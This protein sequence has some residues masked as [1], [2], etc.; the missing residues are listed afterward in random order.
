MLIFLVS[1]TSFSVGTIL[2]WTAPAGPQLK[3]VLDDEYKF[4]V[5]DTA[6]SWIASAM[7]LG[8]A[9]T[10]VPAGLA[11]NKFGR[12]FTLLSSL[13]LALVGWG[14]ILAAT[15]VKMMIFGRIFLGITVGI[16]QVVGS[17]YIGE[18]ATKDI[19]GILGTFLHF[20]LALGVLFVYSVGAGIRIF[21]LSVVCAI[22]PII[23]GAIFVFMPETPSYLVQANKKD[24]AEK[25]LKWLRGESYNIKKELETLENEDQA[26]KL[27][28]DGLSL[29][30]KVKQPGAIRCLLTALALGTY[31]QACGVNIITFYATIIFADAKTD[32][33]PE[34]QT[35]I[36]GL[37]QVITNILS[38]FVVEHLGRRLLMLFSSLGMALS[39]LAL[40]AYFFIKD[41]HPENIE[42]LSWLPLTSMSIFI[43]CYGV[44]VGPIPYILHGE[45]YSP[46]MKGIAV[47]L[48]MTFNWG[49][50][51]LVTKF[52]LSLV[53]VFTTGPTFW[54]FSG[55]NFL[56]CIFIFF[57][58]P[59][60]KGKSLTEI[61]EI[62]G[63]KTS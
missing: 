61:L 50:A 42:N 8:A 24:K 51:F 39:G 62:M 32:L 20:L 59:E 58:I 38:S 37:M 9:A 18:I 53:N 28:N 16:S 23:F 6:L 29:R 34:L 27:A 36:V 31:Q 35:I 12:K 3:N 40:G 11:M 47:G 56:G 13:I 19:R 21:L 5:D 48:A 60:T 55:L 63:G 4:L 45:L 52:F 33:S 10:C 49:T 14:L 17:V 43:C 2:A 1:I 57:A 46:N 54:I 30:E 15:N 41:F 7:T 25:S 26:R 22:V 44:G